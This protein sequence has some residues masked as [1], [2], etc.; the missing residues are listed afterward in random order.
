MLRV[1]LA[2]ALALSFVATARAQTMPAGIAARTE[3]HAIDT[4]TLSDA[5]FLKGDPGGKPTTLTGE[6]RIASGS[7]RL[8]LVMLQHGSGGMGAN[9]EMWS[10]EFNAMGIFNLR[11]RWLYG[12]RTYRR[13]C[14]S[15]AA[16]P[17]ELHLGQLSRVRNFG[18]T[19]S[20]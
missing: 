19:S 15:G 1:A 14:Q 17:P 13:E 3:L 18:Q 9:I 2:G 12:S 20:H 6:L 11:A 7:G 4:L 8:P 5:Q 16:R 10:K